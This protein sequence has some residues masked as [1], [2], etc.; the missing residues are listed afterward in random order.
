MDKRLFFNGIDATT[1]QYAVTPRQIDD[2]ANCIRKR[3]QAAGAFSHFKRLLENLY[4][5]KLPIIKGI[6][7][8]EPSEAGWG[9]IFPEHRAELLRPGLRTLLERRMEECGSLYKELAYR[10]ME[11][12]IE[13]LKRYGAVSGTVN[14]EKVPYYL[15][16]VGS[17][18]DIPFDFQYSLGI[19]RAV[20]RIFFEDPA[21]YEHYAANVFRQRLP[22]HGKIETTFF[23]PEHDEDP[24]TELSCRHLIKGLGRKLELKVKDRID[25]RIEAGEK[26]TKKKLTALM[27]GSETPNLFLG[28]G[29]G[30]VYPCG[31]RKQKTEQGAIVCSD[32]EG[33]AKWNRKPLAPQYF[34]S[35]R[36]LQDGIAFNGMI[37]FLFGCYTAGTPMFDSFP[38][39][40]GGES[41]QIAPHPFLARL[42]IEMLGAQNGCA[43]IIAHVDNA[44][45]WSFIDD[46]ER[47]QTE[48]FQDC[49]L[50]L[51][52]GERVGR[53]LSSFPL[54][55]A[56]M[57]MQYEEVLN[58]ERHYPPHIYTRDDQLLSRL[59]IMLNDMRN[60][61]LLGDPAVKLGGT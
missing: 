24:C 14:P 2:F 36:D 52:D 15:L 56:E 22:E 41:R 20:G 5:R 38:P 46:L 3:P 30:L 61:L 33:P 39:K 49:F 6:N 10:P 23:G 4:K 60:Y 59:W 43:A 26:A 27:G 50:K 57:R 18:E 12:S 47:D 8:N 9:V 17:V 45:A 54:A 35:G 11:T 25:L 16:I 1:G 29:H 21:A 48:V 55:C 31:Y 37:G 13:F 28:A 19:Q 44:E 7:P 58:W 40:P 51:I 32:W 34:F 42:P 53:A